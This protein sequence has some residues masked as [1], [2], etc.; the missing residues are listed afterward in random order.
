[1]L[2]AFPVVLVLSLA[3]CAVQDEVFPPDNEVR[4]AAHALN[5]KD[6]KSIRLD[7]D[8]GYIPLEYRYVSQQ[9]I[10]VT[11]P[12]TIRALVEGLKTAT[13]TNYGNQTSQ[14]LVVGRNGDSLVYAEFSLVAPSHA[15]SPEFVVGL[16]Q[17]GVKEMP[18]E[19]IEKMRTY[20]LAFGVVASLILAAATWLVVRRFRRV[21]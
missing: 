9:S 13:S 15:L 6:V 3:S 2:R 17:A 4:D 12:G 8:Y 11:Q 7:L 16:R 1:M 10:E 5:L 20:V 19:H 14:V 18:W 21:G